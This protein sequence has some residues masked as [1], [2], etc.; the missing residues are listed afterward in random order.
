MYAVSEWE[1]VNAALKSPLF[2]AERKVQLPTRENILVFINGREH[3]ER[4][5]IESPVFNR[6]A[7][8]E[9][10]RATLRPLLASYVQ[11]WREV[12]RTELVNETLMVLVR[13]GALLTGVAPVQEDDEA[14]AILRYVDA[15]SAAGAVE[16]SKLPADAQQQIIR[17]AEESAHEFDIRYVRQARELREPLI[18]RVASG[19]LRE[20]D[21]PRDL[22]TRLMLHWN[23]EWKPIL[24][25]LEILA[26]LTGSVRTS[27]RAVCNAVDEIYRWT[28]QHPE[29]QPLVTDPGFIRKAVNETLRLH[30]VAPVLLRMTA[31]DVT[32]P[33][34]LEIPAGQYVAI[35]YARANRDTRNFG[36]DADEFDPHRGD[37]GLAGRDYGFAFAAGEHACIGRRLAVGAGGDIDGANNGTVMTLVEE[38]MALGA[39]PD[40]EDPPV[41]NDTSFYDEFLR[42]PVRF[43]RR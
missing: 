12:G 27:M 22:L 25:S 26:F 30:V 41:P 1:D 4:R 15:F 23:D 37:R 33:S 34:G 35:L 24:L 2:L 14:R 16:Y 21:L 31:A 10:E 28:V 13:I 11:N 17:H 36:E 42:Y 38:L 20:S 32:L 5:Q 3:L 8:V 29:D 7:L 9:Y 39:E 43:S 40:R 18:A 6:E 19:E